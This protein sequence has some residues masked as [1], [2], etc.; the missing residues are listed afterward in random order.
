MSKC[1]T[2]A[3]FFISYLPLWVSVVF[4]DIKSIVESNMKDSYIEIA[5]IIVIILILIASLIMVCVQ[6]ASGSREN[7]ISYEIKE[8]KEQKMVTFEFLLSYILPLFAYEFTEW[9]GIVLFLIFF[10]TFWFLVARHN[11]FSANILLEIKGYRFY[12]CKLVS[13]DNTEIEMCILSK[14][15][16]IR[17][18]GETV[19]IK[20]LNNE[21]KLDVDRE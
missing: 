20:S 18:K 16:L 10:G 5:S 7:T 12:D 11:V 8:A 15:R 6:L 1:L 2:F 13:I 21:L 9:S 17:M 19:Y 4:M 3:L 14:R